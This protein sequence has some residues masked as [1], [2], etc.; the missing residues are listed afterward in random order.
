MS[1]EDRLRA[2]LE[3]FVRAFDGKEVAIPKWLNVAAVM[4][5]APLTVEMWKSAIRRASMRAFER[6][7]ELYSAFFP[8]KEKD[9]NR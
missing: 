4:D 8:P 9:E 2:D 3:E 6:D 7:M 5:S 1:D